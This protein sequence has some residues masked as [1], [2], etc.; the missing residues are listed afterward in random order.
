MKQLLFFT[1]HN[2]AG[3]I[4]RLTLGFIMLPHGAQKMLGLFGGYGYRA[5]MD[6]FT[7]TMKLPWPLASSIILIEFFCSVGLI[8]GLGS[9]LCAA[10]L[11][12]I[13]L[14]AIAT[15]NYR[16]GFFMNWFGQQSGEGFEYHL[17]VMGLCAALMVTGS[18]KY[19]TDLIITTL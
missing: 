14:G 2:T 6:Y 10:L 7:G 4:L 3:L 9:R 11:G 5:T 17:L 13:M 1:D 8:V 15:T 16:H 12:L 19:S 18:G